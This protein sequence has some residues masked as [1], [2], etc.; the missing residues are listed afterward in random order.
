MRIVHRDL[1]AGEIKLMLHTELLVVLLVPL[2]LLGC[3]GMQ[4]NQS[5]ANA[6]TAPEQPSG[7]GQPAVQEPACPVPEEHC[8]YNNVSQLL[9]CGSGYQIGGAAVANG[10]FYWVEKCQAISAKPDRLITLVGPFESREEYDEYTAEGE[11]AFSE[12]QNAS[13]EAEALSL[14]EEVSNMPFKGKRRGDY[15]FFLYTANGTY[16]ISNE[17]S[18]ESVAQRLSHSMAGS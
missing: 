13:P 17:T 11:R 18:V 5:P 10:S 1:K 16:L 3:V 2:L 6:G 12:L 7:T 8:A 15:V 14:F 4:E 9:T